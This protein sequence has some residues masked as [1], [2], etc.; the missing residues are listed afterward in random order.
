MM[1]SINQS[2]L[3]VEA[4]LSN[5]FS[6]AEGEGVTGAAKVAVAIGVVHARA[7]GPELV[8][9]QTGNGESGGAA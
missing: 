1:V 5:A 9:A 8:Q 7:A 3:S 2:I 4:L 6:F